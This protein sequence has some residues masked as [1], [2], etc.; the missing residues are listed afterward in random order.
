MVK[1]S[2]TK[3]FLDGTIKIKFADNFAFKILVGFKPVFVQKSTTIKRAEEAQADMNLN[4]AVLDMN[5]SAPEADNYNKYIVISDPIANKANLE[6]ATSLND[7]NANIAAFQKSAQAAQT[8]NLSSDMLPAVI[9]SY[10]QDA[11]I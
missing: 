2:K 5:V 4:T 3:E 11:K 6:Q 10:D 8:A 1:F 9:S 7:I